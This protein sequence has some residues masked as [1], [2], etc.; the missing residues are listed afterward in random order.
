M[1]KE[2]LSLSINAD[3]N[4]T[5]SSYFDYYSIGN[6]FNENNMIMYFLSSHRSEVQN[7]LNNIYHKYYAL[8]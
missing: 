8:L 1:N 7:I 6:Q 4:Q 3:N 2:W 5:I